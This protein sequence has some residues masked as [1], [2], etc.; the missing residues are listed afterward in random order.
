MLSS[1]YPV[2]D[3]ASATVGT[4]GLALAEWAANGG[5]L[6]PV[7]VDRALSGGWFGMTF[8]PQGWDPPPVWDS[9]AGD[10]RCAD[11]WIRLHTNDPVHRAAA[12]GVL[13]VSD[14]ATQSVG[15]DLR[16]ATGLELVG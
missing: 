6:A 4:A 3:L 2:A 10:Y 9:V 5:E 13:G 12:L 11:G 1:R 15:A 7:S 14:P 8:T 16:G